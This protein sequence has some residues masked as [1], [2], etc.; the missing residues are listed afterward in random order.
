ML[1]QIM[2]RRAPSDAIPPGLI[3]E[4][5]QAG[6]LLPAGQAPHEPLFP[7]GDPWPESRPASNPEE[8]RGEIER[9]G[10]AVVRNIIPAAFLPRVT[11]Y[12]R[13]LPLGKSTSSFDSAA[14]RHTLHNE[15]LS[16]WLQQQILLLVTSILPEPV[17]PSYTY[18]GFYVPG[19]VLHKHTDREQCEYTISLT[20]DATPSAAASDAWPLYADLKDGST[21]AAPPARATASSS[22]DAT[23]PTIAI[24]WKTAAL[25]GRS[26]CTTCRRPSTV[27]STRSIAGTMSRWPPMH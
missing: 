20:I 26:S 24:P 17:K 8:T 14:R 6:A 5:Q 22:K 16:R 1:W 19:G 9:A 3:D 18:L 23:C 25:R 13:A 15:S 2:T 27:H 10:C 4:L 12:Y 21:L 11:T 7:Y